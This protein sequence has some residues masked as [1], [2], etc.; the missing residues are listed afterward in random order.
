M[1]ASIRL[2]TVG[3]GYFSRFQYSAWARIPEVDLVGICNRDINGAQEVADEYEVTDVFNDFELMLDT[4]KPTLVDIITPPVTHEDY[5]LACIK[6]DIPVI[7]QKPFTPSLEVAMSLSKKIKEKNA[8]VIIHENFRFQPWYNQIKE[9]LDNE[10]LGDLYQ[11]TYRLRPGDGQGPDAYLERQPYFQEMERFLVHETAVHLIDV[12]RYLFGDISSL[13]ADLR[14]I[15][16]VIT[17]EDAGLIVFNFNNGA[18]GVFDGNR[19]SDHKATNR[20]LTM[21]E[22]LIEGSL[23]SL[24]LNGDAEIVF[25][26]HGDN[27]TNPIEYEWN[28]CDFGGDCVYRLQRHVIDHLLHGGELMNSANDYLKNII[29]ADTAYSSDKMKKSIILTH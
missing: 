17:G 28:D 22:M 16:P 20:R 26:A 18:R 21:G 2:A 3:T 10:M 4:V 27:K 24:S 9:L 8:K 23:G 15:N 19:L 14:R 6:R 1:K 13:F 7:C 29:I 12:F 11:I 25:R 5:V